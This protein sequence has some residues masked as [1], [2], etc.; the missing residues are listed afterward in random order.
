MRQ[1][2]NASQ[3][4]EGLDKA[5]AV[6]AYR[7][8]VG[9]HLASL[10]GHPV[11][12]KDLLIVPVKSPAL[13]QELNLHRSVILSDINARIGRDVIRDIRFVSFVN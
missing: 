1:A 10:C 13:R 2:I 12:R 5:K 8:V 3:L 6:D 11:V 4:R 9:E 7:L